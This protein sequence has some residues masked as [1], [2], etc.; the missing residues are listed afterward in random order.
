MTYCFHCSGHPNV[1][2][3]H[4]KTLEFT[5]ETE[6]TR[7]G[8]CVLGV[9]ADFALEPLKQFTGKV[10]VTLTVDDLT[11]TFTA[12]VNPDFVDEHELVFRRGHYASPR[13]FGMRASKSA[14][15][16]SREM[17]AR[18]RHPEA[19]LL[20]TIEQLPPEAPRPRRSAR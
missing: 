4:Y 1:R 18:L 13:T 16:V 9:G 5:R 6:L 8:T 19:R 7:G 11:D 17:I 14:L 15:H 3:T 2:A 12:L 20:V 10:Q